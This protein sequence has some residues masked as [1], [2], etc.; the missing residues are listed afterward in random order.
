M[1]TLVVHILLCTEKSSLRYIKVH[2]QCQ[3]IYSIYLYFNSIRH[4]QYQR[5]HRAAILTKL[6]PSLHCKLSLTSLQLNIAY[7]YLPLA[8]GIII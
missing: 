5:A 1:A 3:K 4:W 2:N 7:Y 8:A 6:C